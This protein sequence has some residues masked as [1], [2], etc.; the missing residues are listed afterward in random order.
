MHSYQEY[1]VV[2]SHCLFV[3]G[4]HLPLNPESS[5]FTEGRCLR[6][7]FLFH[8]F[9]ESRLGHCI[10]LL[11]IFVVYSSLLLVSRTLRLKFQ[12]VAYHLSVSSILYPADILPVKACSSSA[13]HLL[14]LGKNSIGFQDTVSQLPFSSSTCH[15][16]KFEAPFTKVCPLAGWMTC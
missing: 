3:R 2:A 6:S 4:E 9:Q 5:L 13:I 11:Q 7:L 14:I 15:K 12:T 1:S 10:D 8:L 16:I